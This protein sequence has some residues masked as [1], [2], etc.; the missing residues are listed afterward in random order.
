MNKN[1]FSELCRISDEILLQEDSSMER[2]AIPWL[3]IIRWHPIY[4]NNYNSLFINKFSFQTKFKEYSKGSF[5]FTKQIGKFFF[6]RILN[7]TSQE[8]LVT[9]DNKIDFLFVSHLLNESHLANDSD[10]YFDIIPNE[11][12]KSGYSVIIVLINHTNISSKILQEKFNFESGFREQLIQM[13]I[14]DKSELIFLANETDS[15]AQTVYEAIKNKDIK[16]ARKFKT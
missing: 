6:K 3:H 10:F 11:L 2:I 7:I 12:K 14:L 9:K 8:K 1:Q 5:Y 15:P 16:R 13:G 4:L